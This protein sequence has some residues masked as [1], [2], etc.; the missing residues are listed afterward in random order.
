[1]T[2]IKNLIAIDGSDRIIWNREL[3]HL[4]VGEGESKQIL[5]LTARPYFSVK[6]IRL[7]PVRD[8]LA[9]IGDNGVTMVEMPRKWGRRYK[10]DSDSQL[11]CKTFNINER[12]FSCEKRIR[13]LHV[14]WHPHGSEYKQ[15]LCI[16]TNDNR[17]R[18]YD[19]SRNTTETQVIN[20]RIRDE[21]ADPHEDDSC[22]G[23]NMSMLNLG[24][25]SI[26]FDFGPPKLI[27]EKEVLW[28]IYILMGT[29]DVLLIYTNPQN[30]IYAENIIGP[31]T[32]LPQAED[33]YGSDACH[34]IVLDSSPPL[35]A[36]ATPSGRIYHCFAFS[37][38]QGLLAKQTLYMYESIELSKDLIENPDDPYM[39]R[40][41]KL[42]K[43]PT[44]KIRY[45]CVHQ[46]GVHTVVLP[47]LEHVQ[48]DCDIIQD[49]ESFSEFLVCTRTTTPSD[50]NESLEDL[51]TPQGLGVEIRKTN[52]A[53]VVL[54]PDNG[55]IM[56]RISPA[57]TLINRRRFPRQSM[58]SSRESHDQEILNVSQIDASR[59]NFADQI[60][61]I[62]KR[63]TSVPML[64]LTENLEQDNNIFE[65]IERAVTT[66]NNEYIKKFNLANDAIRKKIS[67]LKKDQEIQKAELE[68]I[69]KDKEEV[70]ISVIGLSTKAE[71]AC[72]KQKELLR[73]IDKVLAAV[74]H[75][76][77]DLSEVESR[78]RGELTSLNDKLRLYRD[79]LDSVINK[80]KYH[81]NLKEPSSN[82]SG[83]LVV[84][85]AQLNG[86]KNTLAKQGSDISELKRIVKSLHKT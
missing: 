36:I 5:L 74:S 1:M 23:L 55:V 32:I 47:I 56:Q 66:F 10:S 44:S 31:L 79:Q 70:Y 83:D 81:L 26:C 3:G 18:F 50:A 38:G 25:V 61:Q 28:P 30:P 11:Y 29:G 84:S 62:L 7:S 14:M 75:G 54:M 67:I 80:H 68:K 17:L 52:M 8:L 69:T 76:H 49:K 13:L 77:P 86:I 16:L 41:M 21:Y 43:D 53:L 48:S 85:S 64:K 27:K 6:E 37:D 72:Q 15:T 46:N 45:F 42:F 9:L 63:K 40:P 20:L 65:L 73:R 82:H 58:D 34:L 57:T 24:N 2:S 4:E 78:L 12:L 22:L 35:L 39:P 71:A 60:Q 19:V 59:A 33:N 51:S